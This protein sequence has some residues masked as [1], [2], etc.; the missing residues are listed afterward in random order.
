ML[1]MHLPLVKPAGTP[2]LSAVRVQHPAMV[3]DSPRK[4]TLEPDGA[5][6]LIEGP[7]VDETT[8]MVCAR[9]VCVLPD[10]SIAPESCTITDDGSVVCEPNPD[11]PQPGFSVE[12]L[13]PRGLL[14]FSSVLYGTNFPLGRIMNEALPPS[15][16][17]SARMLFAAL[18]LSPFLLQLSPSLRKMGLLCG[19]FTALG[20]VTQ[21]LALVDTPAATVAFLGA[22]TVLVC[23]ALA[24]LV[25]GRKLGLADAPQ[26]WLAAGLALGGV[27]VLELGGGGG[28]GSLGWGDL[29]SVLQAVGFGTSFFITEKMMAKEPGQALPITATQCAVAA[30]VSGVWALADGTGASLGV[31]GVGS[32]SV[33]G[34]QAGWLLDE[35]TRSSYALPGLLLDDSLRTVCYAALWT[36]LVTTAANRIA[37]TVALGRLASSEASVLLATEPLWAALFAALY[38]G[39]SLGGAD[40]VGGALLVAACLANAVEP[41]ALLGLL[42]LEPPQ[43]EA[44]AS[45]TQDDAKDAS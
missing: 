40:A 4:T 36:G 19:S 33:A 39:E 30:L 5:P 29:F 43:A 28:L 31:P 35:A 41:K 13:W 8:G 2:T 6:E 18:A 32:L 7:E 12:Y 27:G 44:A 42:G 38:I 1:A 15:A 22:V 45:S 34:P 21:S 24:V 14:L 16:A 37:E 10:E 25:D 20:Y 23:P 9:G 26:V 3:I 11:A 17:T